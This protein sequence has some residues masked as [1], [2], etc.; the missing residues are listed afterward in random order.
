MATIYTL[1]AFHAAGRPCQARTKACREDAHGGSR[2]GPRALAMAAPFPDGRQAPP[3]VTTRSAGSQ[4]PS[5]GT[6]EPPGAGASVT[7]ATAGRRAHGVPPAR[8]WT[9]EAPPGCA[10]LPRPPSLGA[11]WPARCEPWAMSGS[12]MQMLAPP[13]CQA[14]ACAPALAPCGQFPP[15]TC[16]G[17]ARSARPTAWSQT[18]CACSPSPALATF[19]PRLAVPCLA[20]A[21]HFGIMLPCPCVRRMPDATTACPWNLPRWRNRHP[22]IFPKRAAKTRLGENAYCGGICRFHGG[23]G[24]RAYCPKRASSASP[25]IHAKPQRAAACLGLPRPLAIFVAFPKAVIC[26]SAPRPGMSTRGATLGTLGRQTA[27]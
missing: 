3:P 10:G 18:Q 25:V 9:M 16:G 6:L 15:L 7:R 13:S 4:T 11:S 20:R 21:G 23:A 8:L 2:P 12:T 5:V 27:P 26:C 19:P 1:Q 17:T 24:R 22:A 14:C